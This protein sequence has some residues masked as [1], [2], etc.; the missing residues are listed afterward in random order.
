MLQ[1][2]LG[3]H[4]WK[5]REDAECLWGLNNFLMFSTFMASRNKKTIK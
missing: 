5:K 1:A 3:L 4:R 2:S